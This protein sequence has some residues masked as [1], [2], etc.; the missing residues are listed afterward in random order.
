MTSEEILHKTI[1]SLVKTNELQAR[2]LEE[3]SVR[4]KELTAQIAW[5]QRQMFGRRS[6]KHLALDNIPSLF[7][8]IETSAPVNEEPQADTSYH[9]KDECS[10]AHFFLGLLS[11]WIVNTIRYRLK[12]TGMTHYWTEIVRMLSTQK[13]ITTEATNAVGETVHLRI[14]SEPTKAVNDIYERLKYK[15][16]PFRKNKDR[17]KFVVHSSANQN[18]KLLISKENTY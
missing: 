3:M 16:M 18:C 11:Y 4:I 15:K 9:Q 14:C 2:Q 7:D 8:N 6:E 13:A 10:D 17:E 5:F 1:D 12:Q